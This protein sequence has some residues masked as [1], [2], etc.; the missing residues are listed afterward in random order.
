MQAKCIV[1]Q[2]LGKQQGKKGERKKGNEFC[3]VVE[4]I[5]MC[6]SIQ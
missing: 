2:G 5:L 4:W 1:I 3:I 6:L